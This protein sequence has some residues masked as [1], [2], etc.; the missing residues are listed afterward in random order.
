MGDNS[1]RI[2]WTLPAIGRRI[3]VGADFIRDTIAKMPNTPIKD[4]GG[5]YYVFENDLL[6]FL[7][8]NQSDQKAGDTD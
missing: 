6:E 5:R 1:E 2:I 3:G 4:I 8:L 7:R